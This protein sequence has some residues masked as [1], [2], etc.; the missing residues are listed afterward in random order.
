MQSPAFRA[1]VFRAEASG[2]GDRPPH[3]QL[4]ADGVPSGDARAVR[5]SGMTTTTSTHDP[6]L[7]AAVVAYRPP[8]KLVP[9]LATCSCSSC[10]VHRRRRSRY[11]DFASGQVF[12]N[13]FIDNAFLLVVAVGM[14]FVILTG[15]I[16]L[17]V[18]SVVALSTMIVRLDCCR[19]TAGRRS[20]VIA[21]GPGRSG[22]CSAS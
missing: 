2:T 6:D 7:V 10:D 17:S 15:G 9:V 3:A 16:D 12:L 4:P 18:G 8:R 22:R 14:T 21:A 19:S 11:E 20:C 13:L 1:K 5:G